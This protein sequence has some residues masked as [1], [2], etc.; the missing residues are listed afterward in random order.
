MYIIKRFLYSSLD[1][2][3]FGHALTSHLTWASIHLK[4]NGL[5]NNITHVC[6]IHPIVGYGF[7]LSH[8][9]VLT[10]GLNRGCRWHYSFSKLF[11]KAKQC[12]QLKIGFSKPKLLFWKYVC[13]RI[14]LILLRYQLWQNLPSYWA[15]M[16]MSL[17]QRPQTTMHVHQIT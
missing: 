12:V 15:Y 5:K 1:R 3:L 6:N 9:I 4:L 10:L 7:K 8:L 13:D 17:S 2:R 11:F 14:N 16:H